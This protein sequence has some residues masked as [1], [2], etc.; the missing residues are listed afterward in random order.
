MRNIDIFDTHP[1]IIEISPNQ[2]DTGT[3]GVRIV[4]KCGKELVEYNPKLHDKLAP[5]AQS[6]SNNKDTE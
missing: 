5:K 3:K 1:H 4:C 2:E 6:K